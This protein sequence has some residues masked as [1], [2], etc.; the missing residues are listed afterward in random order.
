MC[1]ELV[2]CCWFFLDLFSTLSL[3]IKLRF[4]ICREILSIIYLKLRFGICRE[5][6]SIIYL[7]LFVFFMNAIEQGDVV[8]ILKN[9]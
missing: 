1:L 2:N 3:F 7:S 8:G 9:L 5:I 6:L 4:G